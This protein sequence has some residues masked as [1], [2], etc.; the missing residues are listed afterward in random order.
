MKPTRLTEQYS[1]LHLEKKR[2]KRSYFRK[3]KKSK[4]KK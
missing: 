4:M 3:T 2:G 1:I